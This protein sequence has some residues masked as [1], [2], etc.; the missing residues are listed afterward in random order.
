MNVTAQDKN[1]YDLS[2]LIQ[3]GNEIYGVLKKN[4]KE[5]LLGSYK[6]M[7]RTFEIMSE[8]TCLSWNNEAK[9]Y[10]FPMN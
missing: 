10:I 8:A 5:V 3:R 2:E 4:R 6:E 7:T 9:E 1:V